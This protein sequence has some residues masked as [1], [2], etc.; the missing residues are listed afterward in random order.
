P[1][2]NS[3]DPT[4]GDLYIADVGQGAREEVDYQLGK[5]EGGE[6]YGWRCMEG[7]LCTGLSGCTCNDASLTL[8]MHQYSHGGSPFRCSITGGEVYRGCAIPDLQGTYFFGDFCSEQIW[9]F[10]VAGGTTTEFQERTSELDPP[11]A[12]SIDFLT[13]FG[14]DGLGEIYICDQGSSS[15]NGEIFKIVADDGTNKCPPP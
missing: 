9:S 7:T 15:A 4:N 2:R 6:N 5:S 12:Q 10:R 8:P 14:R 1:W 11:G 13:S 3:F